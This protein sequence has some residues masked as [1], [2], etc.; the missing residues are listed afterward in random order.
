MPK[1]ALEMATRLLVLTVGALLLQAVAAVSLASA[2]QA[3]ATYNPSTW[4]GYTI[5]L[6]QACHDGNDGTPGGPCIPNIGCNSF[7]ENSQSFT[8]AVSAAIGTYSQENLIERGYRTIRGTGTA[9]QNI[10]SSN[11][12]GAR[13]HIPLHTNAQGQG[14]CG[15]ST[16]ASVNGT[17]PQYVSS[18]GSRCSDLMVSSIGPASPGTNDRKVY[19]TNLG[20]L[21]STN[22]VACYLEAEYH[23]WPSGVA[24]IQ[25]EGT[26]SW[27]IGW[28][29]DQYFGYP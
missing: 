23:T 25:D 6:S 13:M 26:W 2:A 19:R 21:N 10:A 20:E 8:T 11:A 9:S 1:L 15:G 12:A 17:Q 27:R 18:G 4:N 3:D 16:A 22:A 29:V 14:A 24:W 28:T 7:N 5:Y